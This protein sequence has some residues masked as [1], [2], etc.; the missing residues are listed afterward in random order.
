MSAKPNA[1]IV[2]LDGTLAN[3]NGRLPYGD[4]QANC[5]N[6]LLREDV[7]DM[8]R[9]ERGE[10]E[11]DDP[12]V[13]IVSGRFD[14]YADQ[15]AAWLEKHGVEW[16]ELFMRRADDQ[17]ADQL[18]KQEIY[19]DFIEPFFNVVRVYDDRPKVIRMWRELGLDVV[20]VGS[21]VEF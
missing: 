13:L 12:F 10:S 1:L 7:L 14:T 15:T 4:A 19:E 11:D 16:D 2:D 9:D 20:D 17:R 3:L 18:I 8:V 21:G 6:D 5:G